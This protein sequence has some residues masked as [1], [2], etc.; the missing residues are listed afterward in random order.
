MYWPTKP[1]DSL[2]TLCL[3]CLTLKL[4]PDNWEGKALLGKHEGVGNALAN[5]AC[6]QT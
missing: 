4:R 6:K 3:E 2:I 5:K 1:P